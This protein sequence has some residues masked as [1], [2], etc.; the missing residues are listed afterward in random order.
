MK[1]TPNGMPP[2]LKVEHHANLEAIEAYE[3]DLIAKLWEPVDGTPKE[4]IDA[5]HVI[6]KDIEKAQ[7]VKNNLIQ[8]A[9]MK[10]QMKANEEKSG[11]ILPRGGLSSV[12]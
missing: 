3:R 11:L 8:V 7:V 12:N 5:L 9:Y 2:D 1:Q 6:L 4:A 10:A